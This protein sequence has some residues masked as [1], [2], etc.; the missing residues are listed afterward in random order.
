MNN[1]FFKR[2]EFTEFLPKNGVNSIDSYINYVENADKQFRYKL[3]E[4]AENIYK[5][6]SLEALDEL[7]EIGEE[8]FEIIEISSK[9]HYRAGFIKYL[10]FIEEEIC[11]SHK[12]SHTSVLLDNV[13]P[14][15]N[16]NETDGFISYIDKRVKSTLYGRLTTQS[17][18]N[19]DNKIIFPIRF[20]RTVYHKK[21]KEDIFRAAIKKQVED[22]IYYVGNTPKKISNLKE[23]KI[24]KDGSVLINQEK[25]STKTHL[26][27]LVELKVDKR[28]N[29][30]EIVIDHIEPISLILANLDKSEFPQFTLISNEFRKKAKNGILNSDLIDSI[31]AEIANDT[32]FLNKINFT[33]FKKEFERINSK[34]ELQLMHRSYNSYKGAK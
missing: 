4:I 11:L 28:D 21:G 1:S 20:I 16:I 24:L 22:I 33:D 3:F 29:L 27:N 9:N 30:K 5:A 34:M 19:N 2:K 17:R 32:S 23:L 13:R 7:R 14:K 10:D 26:G 6:R 18:Y 8:L 25:I 12:I 15:S 31:G